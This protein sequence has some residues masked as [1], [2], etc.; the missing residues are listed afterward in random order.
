MPL[1]ACSML[2]DHISKVLQV[3]RKLYLMH[4]LF[5]LSIFIESG[6]VMDIKVISH[7]KTEN[8]L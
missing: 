1:A 7:L 4:L 6:E 5:I 3:C 8:C 2:N